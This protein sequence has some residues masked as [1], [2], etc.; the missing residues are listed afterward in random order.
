MR[1]SRRVGVQLHPKGTPLLGLSL[2]PAQCRRGTGCDHR[3]AV[4]VGFC[5]AKPAVSGREHTDGDR[6]ARRWGG[7]ADQ[8]SATMD[9]ISAHG[10]C[11]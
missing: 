10:F 8:S 6:H 7:T 3:W 5:R 2:G 1:A 11:V 4:D 9:A